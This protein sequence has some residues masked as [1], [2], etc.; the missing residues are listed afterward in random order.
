MGSKAGSGLWWLLCGILPVTS[1]V[2]SVT[3]EEAGHEPTTHEPGRCVARRTN[4]HFY[5]R[6]VRSHFSKAFDKHTLTIFPLLRPSVHSPNHLGWMR[7]T[8]EN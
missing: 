8:G 5:S 1:G 2:S 3:S 4:P 6:T 7:C